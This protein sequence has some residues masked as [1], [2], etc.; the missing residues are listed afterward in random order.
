MTP[1]QHSVD[2]NITK[3]NIRVDTESCFNSE[4]LH[5]YAKCIEWP[6]KLPANRYFLNIKT[7]NNSVE[8]CMVAHF[9]R[10]Y[11]LKRLASAE[12][13]KQREAIRRS[14]RLRPVKHYKTI[15]RYER[16]FKFP[17]TIESPMRIDDFDEIE[18]ETNTEIFLYG[19]YSEND[20]HD[21]KVIR[22]GN[23][24]MV[25]EKRR[26]YLCAL[27][28]NEDAVNDDIHHVVLIKNI[29]AFIGCF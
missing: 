22:R 1:I 20:K 14:V 9:H 29:Q 27:I 10:N 25:S 26:I 6:A 16:Y 7:E 21:I 3:E 5:K 2:A 13:K 8:L 24:S 19:I 15:N 4:S 23:N 12:T 17:G 28:R 18:K 11:H